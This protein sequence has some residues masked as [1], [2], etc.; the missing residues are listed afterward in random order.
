MRKPT[1]Q[2]CLCCQLCDRF[3]RTD[4][5]EL[6]L[7]YGVPVDIAVVKLGKLDGS[8]R[9]QNQPFLCK[10]HCAALV[11]QNELVSFDCPPMQ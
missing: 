6:L 10:P 11:G 8:Q 5:V 3:A 7:R 2:G 1:W 4:I 9:P